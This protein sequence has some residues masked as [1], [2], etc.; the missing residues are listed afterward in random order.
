M[1]EFGRYPYYIDIINAMFKFWYRIEH[2]HPDSLLYNALECSKNIEVSINSWYN[3]IN[4]FQIFLPLASLVVMKQSTFNAKLIKAL[5]NKYLNE[6]H[7]R[8]QTCSVDKLDLCSNVKSS[9]GFEKY[10]KHLS[11][12]YRR[13]ITRLR[14]SSHKLNIEIG[15][16]ARV[17][18]L[19]L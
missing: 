2:R 11:F 4:N 18:M 9:F 3:T 12:P 19:M 8:K 10:L 1:S 15:R 16:Y 6:W 7:S 17:D 13:D 14:I 5:K